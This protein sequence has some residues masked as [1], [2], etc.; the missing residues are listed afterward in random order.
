LDHVHTYDFVEGTFP[1]PLAPELEQFFPGDDAYFNY[2]DPNS[3]ESMSKALDNLQTFLKLEGPYD[4]VMAFSQGAI[5][6]AT[7]LIQQK[8]R[9]PQKPLPF[10]CAI[11]LSGGIPLDPQA[12]EQGNVQ[13]LKEEDG[14][15]HLMAGLATAHI[16]GR[17]DTLFPGTSD[18]LYALSDPKL[19]SIFLHDEGHSIPAARSKYAVS[20]AVKAIRRAVDRASIVV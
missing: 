1:A 11:F 15:R 14:N 12:L 18:V 7:Y 17:N 2:F 13:R 9:H 6:V 19:G 8:L 10:K 16:W 5:L 3:V 4:G 20:G